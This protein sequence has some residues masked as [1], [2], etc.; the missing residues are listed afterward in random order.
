MGISSEKLREL[1]DIYDAALNRRYRREKLRREAPLVQMWDG[2]WVLRGRVAG[3]YEA[4][5]EWKLNDTG[6]GTVVLPD[7]HYLAKW[8][9]AHWER[10]TKNIHI[11]VDK[12]G[13]RWSGRL[14]SFDFEQDDLGVRRVTLNFLH[15]YE[16]L[17][18]VLVWSNPMTPA[19]VQFPRVFMLAGPSKYMLKLALFLN[20]ARLQGN[21]WALPDDP[22]D[23][24]SWS[25]IVNLGEWP[26]MVKPDSLL[27]DDSEWTIL[28]SRFKTWHDMA[29]ST[30]EDAG[31]MVEC[32]RW[33]HGDPIP[34]GFAEPRNGQL[35]VD[36]VD[37]GGWFGQTSVG[38]TILGGLVR[39]GLSVA[40]DLVDDTREALGQVVESPGYAVS[41]FL[42]TKPENPWVVFRT[43]VDKGTNVAEST[44]YSY[45]PAT[46]TQLVAGGNSAPGVNEAITASL[47][48]AGSVASTYLFIP[49]IGAPAATLLEPIFEDTL[50][51]FM[52]YKSL[53]RSMS[54][55]WSHYYED[56]VQGAD[57]AYTLSSIMAMRRG[58]L[59]TR[60]KTTHTL[61][62]G[63]GGPYLIGENGQGHF[64]LGDRV[65]AEIPGMDGRVTVEQVSNLTLSWDADTVHQ[66]QITIGDPHAKGDGD[67][68]EWIVEQVK[69]GA[70]ALKDQ[71]VLS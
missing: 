71:G 13:A 61:T 51:A 5:F 30:L 47:Q 43:D 53:Q 15:D 19:A 48:L 62:V 29:K 4:S 23:V 58:M 12:D 49:N 21:W 63:D 38:G 31:L 65:G 28:S 46:V 64:F 24:R 37:K 2:D 45:K 44:S 66:W 56:W 60:Q 35:I 17:K 39:T 69:D 55:G 41:G 18:H 10:K 67:P 36:I 3:E 40:D 33:L 50:F 22:L 25:Q 26:I 34:W 16:E 59:E 11:T 9:V 14:E 68:V 57:K 70:A 52:S 54:L 42:G 6:S 7:D 27:L 32:R 1:D 20:L 8:A